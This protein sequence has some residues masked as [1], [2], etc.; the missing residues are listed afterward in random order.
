MNLK[1]LRGIA[2]VALITLA[3]ALLAGCS[4]SMAGSVDGSSRMAT[5]QLS[6][7]G[8]PEEYAEEFAAYCARQNSASSRSILP[9][10]P[11]DIGGIGSG[12]GQSDGLVLVLTGKSETGMTFG[13]KEVTLSETS[14]GSGIYDFNEIIALDAMSWN[15]VLTAYSDAAQ[16]KKVLVG[17]CS[18]DLRNGSGTATFVMGI[19]GLKTPGSV[20]IEGTIVDTDKAAKSYTMGIYR[21]DNGKDV[22]D[23]EETVDSFDADADPTFTFTANGKD[24]P[25]GTYL[26]TMK[27]YK[28]STKKSIVGSFTDTIVINPGNALKKENLLIDVIGKKPSKP[29][30]LKAYLVDGLQYSTGDTYNVKVTWTQSEYATNYELN[31]VEFDETAGSD[32]NT[33]FTPNTDGMIVGGQIYGMASMDDS[34]DDPDLKIVKDFPGSAVFDEGSSSMMYGDD[35]CVLKLETGKLYEIQLRARN[36]IGVSDWADREAGGTET[37]CT[38]YAAPATQRINRLLVTY[39]LGDGI[40]AMNGAPNSLDDMYSE[41]K[42]WTEDDDLL[43]ITT[44]GEGGNKLSNGGG[45]FVAWLLDSGTAVKANGSSTTTVGDEVTKYTY[46]NVTVIASF[47]NK[48]TG[49]VSQEEKIKDVDPTDIKVMYGLK[50]NIATNLTGTDNNYAIPQSSGERYW[51]QITLDGAGVKYTNVKFEVWSQT[52]VTKKTVLQTN[53][54]GQCQINTG[55]YS[56][57]KVYVMVTADT[58]NAKGMS[59]TLTFDVK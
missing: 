54:V 33:Y 39:K 20:R 16:T 31:V 27:F 14:S 15:L 6:A 40:L 8:I 1:R 19:A 38:A 59:Q 45:K 5:L 56:A 41:Y 32:I 44:D 13:P 21:K 9:D 3:A 47:G 57:G 18:V 43:V 4:N 55:L 11:F 42:S 49:N 48:V 17:Y 51:I 35:S 36:Y 23:T 30:N 12:S 22:G 37:G 7:T 10:D 46:K 29:K 26:Y 25:P 53:V 24:V 52:N 58:E 28:D 2:S 34:T 50:D